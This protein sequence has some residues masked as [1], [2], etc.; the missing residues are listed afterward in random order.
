MKKIFLV[1]CSAFLFSYTGCFAQN[2]L[3]KIPALPS[4]QPQTEE[5]SW[6]FG[7][8]KEGLILKHDFL[9]KNK[10][11]KTLNITGT[12]TSCGCT[13][14]KVGKNTLSPAEETLIE[15]KFN[16]AGYSGAVTQY[17]YVNT[18][19]PENPI[20]KFTVKAQVI[21]SPEGPYATWNFGEIKEGEIVRHNFVLKNESK[22]P[23]NIIE[24]KTTCGC[25]GTKIQKNTLSPGEGTFLEVQFNSK[26]Y[27]GPV[28]KSIYVQTDNLDK[29]LLT[30][31]IKAKVI[32]KG[33]LI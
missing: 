30:F 2:N 21:K 19:N 11:Q 20:L 33:R 6:D 17:I 29:P 15:A 22:N 14:S 26:G 12:N 4:P 5:Y 18:D 32:K 25:T 28:E 13:V 3:Q 27:S 16:S 24:V 1:L 9:L 8:V 31:I 7:Q 10:S 23:L